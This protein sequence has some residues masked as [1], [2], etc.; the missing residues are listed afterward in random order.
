MQTLYS[1]L[2]DELSKE[3]LCAYLQSKAALDFTLAS[4]FVSRPAYFVEHLVRLP[5]RAVFLDCGAY[6]GDTIKAFVERYPDYRAIYAFEPSPENA[7]KLRRYIGSVGLHDCSV[8][9]MGTS[10]KRE[11]LRFLENDIGFRLDA[12][13]ALAI[14]CDTVDHVLQGVQTISML[15]M[16][17]EGAELATL[18]GATKT[19]QRDRPLLA[20]S[21]Y[22]APEDLVSVA[23]FIDETAPGYR[24]YLRM[25]NPLHDLILYA[26][27][28]ENPLVE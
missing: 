20:I 4:S 15:K 7:V 6:D 11:T 5:E 1:R 3:L 26:V 17:I 19:I 10:D 28:D 8:F 18:K 22:H 13:G 12:Q 21:V 2:A 24:F 16:D 25:H 9:E 23:R 14:E 27:L